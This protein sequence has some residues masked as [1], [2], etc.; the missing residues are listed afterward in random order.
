MGVLCN[1]DV[2]WE[3]NLE[4]AQSGVPCLSGIEAQFRGLFIRNLCIGLLWGSGKIICLL[5]SHNADLAVPMPEF[6]AAF[7]LPIKPKP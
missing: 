6:R 5:M 3:L 4:L 2:A 1:V 7:D